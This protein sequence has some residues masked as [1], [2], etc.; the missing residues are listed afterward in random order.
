M[1]FACPRK[2]LLEYYGHKKYFYNP[3]SDIRVHYRWVGRGAGVT[4]LD[5]IDLCHPSSPE[6]SVEHYLRAES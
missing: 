3:A 2:Y 4:P 5:C 1:V 6:Y